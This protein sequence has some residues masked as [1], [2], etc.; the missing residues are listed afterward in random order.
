MHENPEGQAVLKTFQTTR[1]DSFPEGI[2]EATNRMREM[3]EI[4]KDIPLP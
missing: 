2:D 4:V 3:M 1:F